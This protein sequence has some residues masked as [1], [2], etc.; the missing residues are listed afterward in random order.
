MRSFRVWHSSLSPQFE[1]PTFHIRVPDLSSS[2]C[3]WCSSLQICLGQSRWRFKYL[4]V[5]PPTRMWF[6][7]RGL[8]SS[9]CCSQPGSQSVDRPLSHPTFVSVT[10]LFKD[11]SIAFKKVYFGLSWQANPPLAAQTFGDYVATCIFLKGLT[12]YFT[13][14][15][16]SLITGLPVRYPH[17]RSLP[18]LGGMS[19]CVPTITVFVSLLFSAEWA[20]E[21][22]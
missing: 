8:P 5:L 6:L 18:A 4:S 2:Y 22:F 7:A 13:M 20:W 10:L 1:M 14:L 16:L 3:F 21:F 12:L 9:S 19:R 17:S 15:P 11:T